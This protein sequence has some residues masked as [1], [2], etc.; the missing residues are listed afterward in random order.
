MYHDDHYGYGGKFCYINTA[1]MR[2]F[3]FALPI[4]LVLLVNFVMFLCITSKISKMMT[5]ETDVKERVVVF[6]KLSTITGFYWT[7]GYIYE[8]T[9]IWVFEYLFIILNG[10]QGFF[11][12]WSFLLNKRIFKMYKNVFKK[13]QEKYSSISES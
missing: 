10:G 8:A 2:L 4:A 1:E 13:L 11:L 3:T 7:F 6:L 9:K 12:M 5:H